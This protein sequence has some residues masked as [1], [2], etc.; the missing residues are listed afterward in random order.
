MRFLGRKIYLSVV[1]ILITALE[2]GLTPRRRQALAEHLDLSPK[3][4]YRWRRWWRA[5]FAQSQTWRD[6]SRRLLPPPAMAALP[7]ALL[8]R[9]PGD[10]LAARL[11]ALLT[12]LLALTTGSCAGFVVGEACPQ[13]MG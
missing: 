11:L 7:G 1:V 5:V 6:L 13:K 3:T 9:L 12:H 8:G 2:H 10:D 4:L